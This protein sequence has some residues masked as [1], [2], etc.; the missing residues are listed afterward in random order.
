MVIDFTNR[1]NEFR[2]V[3]AVPLA[4]TIS[5][6]FSYLDITKGSDRIDNC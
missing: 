3:N 1:I 6:F 5:G 4:L 2:A